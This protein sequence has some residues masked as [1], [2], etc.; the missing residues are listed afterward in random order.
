VELYVPLCNLTPSRWKE[1][2]YQ[3]WCIWE[4]PFGGIYLC[5]EKWYEFE[6]I[7]D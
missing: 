3:C 7:S 1:K 4:F 6:G 5:K 2:T